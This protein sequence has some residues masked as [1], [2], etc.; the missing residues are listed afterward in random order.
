M[1]YET[2]FGN[3]E[4]ELEGG[5]DKDL[6][7]EARRHYRD[8]A[9]ETGIAVKEKDYI[10]LLKEEC[11]SL[12]KAKIK[13]KAEEREKSIER[14]ITT[15]GELGDATNS[16]SEKLLDW[17]GEHFPELRLRREETLEVIAKYGSR[18][19]I[20]ESDLD[21]KI[22]KKAKE[23]DGIELSGE[24]EK[25]LRRFSKSIKE[26]R[27][28]ED[29]LEGYVEGNIEAITPNLSSFIGPTLV[30]K[31]LSLSGGLKNLAF[32]PSSKIQV[33]G[34]EKALF[35]HLSRGVP[36]PK[37]GVIFQHPAIHNSKREIRGKLARD[38]AAKIAILA[39][40]DYF[41]GESRGDLIEEFKDEIKKKEKHK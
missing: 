15:M 32:M 2:W 8:Y 5:E 11:I 29:E 12:A 20:I 7:R 38:L 39:R 23:S 4:V 14:A 41:S 1:R 6:G 3:I 31:L 34:A 37:H 28:L 24:E 13:L 25:I 35:K 40:V 33:L 16:L 27:E 17:Y 10:E 26:M 19:R 30:A 18:K 22:I 36:P 21:E 9:R